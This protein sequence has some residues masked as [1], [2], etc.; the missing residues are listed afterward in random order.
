MA[1]GANAQLAATMYQQ[2]AAAKGWSAADA[3]KGIAELLLTC[4]VQQP[5][6]GWTPFVPRG[7]STP[8]DVVVYRER[9]DF[10]FHNGQPSEVIRRADQL[11]QYLAAQLGCA[12]VNLCPTIAKFWRHP[13]VASLQMH[14]LVGN[15]FRSIIVDALK[16]Y[17]AQGLTYDE[18]VN[19][20]DAFP[21]WKFRSRSRLGKIDIFARRGKQPVAMFSTRWRYRHD[22]V[23]FIHEAQAYT[24]AALEMYSGFPYYAVTG[25]FNPARL[26]KVLGNTPSPINAV[27]HFCPDLITKGLGENGRVAQLQ[28]LEWLIQQTHTW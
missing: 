2:L 19:Y 3:W 15:A 8:L 13:T 11:S 9:N 28:S 4:E 16:L 14:N 25:E 6:T 22:R 17:G 18:E 20:T 5:G 23:D 12:R 10:V 26:L 1:R 27:V 21:G 24:A 7:G